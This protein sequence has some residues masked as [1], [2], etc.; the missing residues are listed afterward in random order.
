MPIR[1][2]TSF[3]TGLLMLLLAGCGG[4]GSGSSG[5]S[6]PPPTFS[7]SPTSIEVS[8]RPGGAAPVASVAV[9]VANVPASSQWSFGMEFSDTTIVVLGVQTLSAH[10]R[11]I[12]LRFPDPLDIGPGE[13]LSTLRVG[14]C[15]DPACNS[16]ID[17]GMRTINLRYFVEQ[18][19]QLDTPALELEVQASTFYP[20]VGPWEVVPIEMS[21]RPEQVYISA[22]LS[23]A[24]L[25]I[26]TG[27]ANSSEPLNLT[28]GFLAPRDLGPGVYDGTVT[29]HVCYDASCLWEIQGSP[30][31][32]NTRYTVSD[33]P[34]ADPEA[35]PVPVLRRDVLPHDVVDAA[36]ST[37]HGAIVMVSQSPAPALHVHDPLTGLATE[38]ALSL[39]P[40]AVAVAPDG[41]SA[42]IGH[43]GAVSLVALPQ[44]GQPAPSA[45]VEFPSSVPV[46]AL[47]LDRRGRVHIVPG[48][49]IELAGLHT[50]DLST[51]AESITENAVIRR[52]RVRLHPGGDH[53]LVANRGQPYVRV[54]DIQSEQAIVVGDETSQG[55]PTDHCN[56]L[57][58]KEDGAA[59]Y[60]R[61]GR[62]F[63]VPSDLS[64][65]G[66]TPSG[67]LMLTEPMS[68]GTP[69][70]G[71]SQS[72][73][74]GEILALEAE[75]SQCFN[76]SDPVQGCLPRLRRYDSA[77][78]APLTLYSTG[79]VEL[80][81]VW[82]A[83]RGLFL[84][85][86]ATGSERFMVS[87]THGAPGEQLFMVSLLDP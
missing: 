38:I 76:Y 75:E 30:V 86:S 69:I 42:A 12:N 79:F 70:T 44:P 2:P 25:R 40:T 68:W 78:L 71:L 32:V 82:Y 52:S 17:G 74:R 45:P 9:T 3:T 19:P 80:D 85:H 18:H 47:A 48:G 31:V 20:G 73:A 54:L 61:C 56:D 81:D 23:G 35:A 41:L 28:V 37:A 55:S 83:Q 62:V 26:A 15:V 53:L 6:Q 29:A 66:L 64:A 22:V 16:F 36:F 5:T 84:F 33:E 77:S 43:D 21:N 1:P 51:G 7:L 46:S 50:L 67:N 13:H 65:D 14:V 57:W 10:A 39:A 8:A 60:T 63:G 72:D 11:Q 24:G 27:S 49:I 87:R 34:P 59:V 4:G 58:L